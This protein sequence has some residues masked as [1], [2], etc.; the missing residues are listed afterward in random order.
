MSHYTPPLG[1]QKADRS[2]VQTLWKYLLFPLDVSECSNNSKQT[3]L[4]LNNARA[5]ERSSY[6]STLDRENSIT[7]ALWRRAL[8]CFKN[9]TVR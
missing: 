5:S 8:E 3:L 1:I 7:S 2:N 4:E 9:T 6:R